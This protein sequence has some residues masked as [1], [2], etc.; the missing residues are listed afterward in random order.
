[1]AVSDPL[2][3]TLPC[4]RERRPEKGRGEI[5]D[6]GVLCD[7]DLPTSM[8]LLARS[9]TQ[10]MVEMGINQP[11]CALAPQ[12]PLVVPESQKS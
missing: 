2:N 4:H 10:A 12:E 1:M 9:Y 11:H 7:A 8:S 5:G 6:G 3:T